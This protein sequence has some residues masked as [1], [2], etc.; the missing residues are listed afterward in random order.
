MWQAVLHAVTMIDFGRPLTHIDVGR[1][2]ESLAA[3]FLLDHGHTVIDRNWYARGEIR[4][5][6]DIVSTVDG[7]LHV[8]EVKTRTSRACGI[9]PEAITPRKLSALSQLT[10]LWLRGQERR[11]TTVTIDVIGIEVAMPTPHQLERASVHLIEG[12][13]SWR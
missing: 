1:L 4:G 10:M 11:F 6:L 5:E 13:T 9:A 8:T 7:A 12:V 2:G 3:R